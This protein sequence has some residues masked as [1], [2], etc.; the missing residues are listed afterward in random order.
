M[1]NY[2]YNNVTQTNK[3]YTLFALIPYEAYLI[4]FTFISYFYI[5]LLVA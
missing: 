3:V 4:A 1:V 2:F 5:F